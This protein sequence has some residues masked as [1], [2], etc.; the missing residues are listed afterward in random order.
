M[1]VCLLCLYV[2]LS[3]VGRGLCGGLI[4]RSEES[5]CVFLC[6]WSRNPER[7]AK[8]PSWTISACEWMNECSKCIILATSEKRLLLAV[9]TKYVLVLQ[10]RATTG[11]VFV[12]RLILFDWPDF[13]FA[14]GLIALDRPKTWSIKYLSSAA[15]FYFWEQYQ[16]YS[17]SPLLYNFDITYFI[18]VS[19]YITFLITTVKT[20]V[21]EII[22]RRSTFHIV[23]A[24][25]DCKQPWIVGYDVHWL[26][27]LA[28]RYCGRA[29]RSRQKYFGGTGQW[30][31]A[32]A[33]C[34]G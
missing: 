17:H 7:E 14:D 10:S 21:P 5:Y 26:W 33:L 11:L 15:I 25:L 30:R 4:T 8:G 29:T 24:L 22:Y 12:D 32:F 16:W 6:M 2:V 18:T 20:Q 23:M 19:H 34:Y 28:A 13:Y 31:L 9:R 1:D 27:T 3:C